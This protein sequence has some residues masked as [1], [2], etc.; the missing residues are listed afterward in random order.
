MNSK[1]VEGKTYT[2]FGQ[3]SSTGAFYT[4]V[5][6]FVD[7]LIAVNPDQQGLL[8]QI[9]TA[10]KSQRLFNKWK[11]VYPAFSE[12]SDQLDIYTRNTNQH[13]KSL[14]IHKLFDKTLRTKEWQYHLFMLEA[15]LTNRMNK[16]AFL[17]SEY[18]MALLPYCL[19]DLKKECKSSS[20]GTEYVCRSC[21]S[22]CYINLITRNLKVYDVKGYLWMASKLKTLFGSLA[23]DYKTI[24]VI[25]IACIPELVNGMRAC[26][27]YNIPAIGI[28]LDANRCIRWM[29]SFHENSVNLEQLKKLLTI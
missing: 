28:P 18:K 20:D 3:S 25:G 29:G 4:V 6:Q 12:R 14:K 23:K 19:H 5:S 16:Q 24:G 11:V 27:K 13:L 7:E 15:E 1:R 2:L 17:E 22:E 8:S 10:A 9:Q 26:A 21:S